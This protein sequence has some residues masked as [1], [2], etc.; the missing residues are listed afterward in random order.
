MTQD[1]IPDSPRVP[2]YRLIHQELQEQIRSGQYPSGHKMPSEAELVERFGASRLTIARAIKEL[3]IEGLVQRR[4]G[5]GTYVR[6]PE[7]VNGHLHFGLLIPDLGQ[8]EIFELIC[9]G[10]A[11]GR[12][13]DSYSLV[14]GKTSHGLRSPELQAEQLCE[15][16]IAK[17]VAGIFFAPLELTPAKDEVNS[18]IA[19]AFNQAGIPVILLD[20]DICSYPARSKYDLVGIDNRRAG[21]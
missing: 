3:Q 20:R 18:R 6:Q 2:K 1:D 4:A 11:E 14:W 15:H 17:R 9:Q 16:Y 5:S 19:E 8:T 13:N 7:P 10:I 21:Y 12:Q